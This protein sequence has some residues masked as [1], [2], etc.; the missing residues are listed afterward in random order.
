MAIADGIRP[1]M[2]TLLLALIVPGALLAPMVAAGEPKSKPAKESPQ[3]DKAEKYDPDN[4]TA[5]SQYMETVAKATERFVAKDTTSATDLYKKAIQLSPRNPLAPYLLA[6]VY[7]GANNLGEA[8]AALAQAYDG[9]TKNAAVRSHVL[10]LRAVILERQKKQEDAKVAWQ[11]YTEHAAKNSD[12]GTF[13]Q[14]GAERIR[15]IQKVLELEKAY[16]GVR[17]RIVAE[18]ADAGKPAPATPAKK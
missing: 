7:L 10:F 12:A 14:S 3:G 11:A 18:K 8:D 15:A 1:K 4:V 17:E 5:I 2:R 9:D 13:P 16:V 6:E